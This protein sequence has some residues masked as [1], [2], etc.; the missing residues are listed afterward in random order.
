MKKMKIKMLW[1][2]DMTTQITTTIANNNRSMRIKRG[3][4]GL[5]AK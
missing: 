2:G 3:K 5:K 1:R 4:I